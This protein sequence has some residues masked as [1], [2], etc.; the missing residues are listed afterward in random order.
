M[1]KLE[2]DAI[3]DRVVSAP[4]SHRPWM[5]FHSVYVVGQPRWQAPLVRPLIAAGEGGVDQLPET[6]CVLELVRVDGRGILRLLFDPDRVTVSGCRAD[7][8]SVNDARGAFHR[9]L[10][11]ASGRHADRVDGA[12]MRESMGHDVSAAQGRNERLSEEVSQRVVIKM[13]RAMQSHDN[14]THEKTKEARAA[15][16]KARKVPVA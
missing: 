11:E 15:C 2:F 4:D 9:S 7:N 10:L 14:C 6:K 1:D 12:V 8:P 16:R 5:T 13:P 3:V